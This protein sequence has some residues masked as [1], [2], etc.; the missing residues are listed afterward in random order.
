[1][2]ISITDALLT[3]LAQVQAIYAHHVLHG[4]ATFETEPP[5]LEEMQQRYH[6]VLRQGLPFLVAV[7]GGQVVGYC[8]LTPYR[9]RCAYRY[10]LENSIYV[11]P[12]KLG[13]G[14]GKLLL[15]AALAKAEVL[16]FRQVIA[17]IGNSGNTGSIGLHHAA[18][19][20]PV[21]TLTAV[22]LKHGRWIDTVIMQRALGESHMTLPGHDG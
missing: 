21:G 15:S 11:H 7:H 17:V 2:N 6:E 22:G 4:I 9:P 10:T 14:I 3:D 8:Y 12:E 20:K 18:G 16:G 13:Q 19:F 1:M 5:E